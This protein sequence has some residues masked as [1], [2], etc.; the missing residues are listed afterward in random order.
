MR[1][2]GTLLNGVTGM[3]TK[4]TYV[5][6]H[7]YRTIPHHSDHINIQ[8]PLP[9]AGPATGR[10]STTLFLYIHKRP[11]SHHASCCIY[12]ITHHA[13]SAL[14]P[15]LAVAEQQVGATPACT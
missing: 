8:S 6:V 15:K 7:G 3:R 9:L 4:A 11:A 10:E 2:K 13:V 14:A 5:K 12:T 1:I